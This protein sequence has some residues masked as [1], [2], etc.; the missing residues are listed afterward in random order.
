PPG[1]RAGLGLGADAGRRTRLMVFFRLPLTFPHRVWLLLWSILALFAAIASWV[2][3][4]AT[5]RPPAGL[6]R[7]LRTYLRYEAHVYSFFTLAANPFPGFT[8]AVGS[9]PV[10]VSVAE[11]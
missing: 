1:V 3:T 4:L 7:F 8:G 2:W 9:Y 5:A 10:E 6:H 11:P